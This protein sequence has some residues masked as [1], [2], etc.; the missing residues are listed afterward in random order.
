MHAGN[1]TSAS[2]W[3]RTRRAI[4]R[5]RRRTSHCPRSGSRKTGTSRRTTARTRRRSGGLPGSRPG[6]ADTARWNSPVSAG[7]LL[8]RRHPR[9]AVFIQR[10]VDGEL[11]LHV[12][13]VIP[14]GGLKP[15]RHRIEARGFWRE[16]PRIGVRAAY[17]QG[18]LEKRWVLQL[19]SV[20]KGVE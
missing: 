1:G 15:G 13:E 10:I 14:R 4:C 9:A 8:G 2:P 20:Q 7:P 11:L 17:D 12:V 6:T 19:V 3:Q 16:A 18:E 5:N